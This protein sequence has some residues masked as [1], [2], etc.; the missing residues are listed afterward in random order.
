[1]RP[2]NADSSA[3]S[4]IR[5]IF[6]LGAEADEQLRIVKG[7]RPHGSVWL[8]VLDGVRTP[9]QARELTGRAVAI[10]ESELP[11]LRAGEF[12]HYQLIGLAVVGEHGQALGAVSDVLSASGNHVLVVRDGG[13]ERLIPLIDRVVREIDLAARRIVVHP[14]DGL[15][16]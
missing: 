12:Y 1:M 11:A 8:L 16:D 2:F 9:E 15:L 13:R 14:I 7:A 4:E 10:P 3:P 5:E 6:L